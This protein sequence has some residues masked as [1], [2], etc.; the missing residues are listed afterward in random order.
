MHVSRA[1]QTADSRKAEPGPAPELRHR[2]GRRARAAA[3]PASRRRCRAGQDPSSARAFA[4]LLSPGPAG[5]LQA[6]QRAEACRPRKHT[7]FQAIIVRLVFYRRLSC[8]GKSGR[9]TFSFR[10]TTPQIQA[11]P[12]FHS[13]LLKGPDP[14]KAR[15]RFLSF[16]PPPFRTA[17]VDACY[18][19]PG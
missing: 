4:A 8:W 2:D 10:D 19:V 1:P 13:C 5:T 6:C 17:S 16:L 14:V 7:T 9:K 15:S 11:S 3:A 12:V 18:T